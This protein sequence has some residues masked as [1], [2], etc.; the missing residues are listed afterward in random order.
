MLEIL[1]RSAFQSDI[2]EFQSSFP[3]GMVWG[4]RFSHDDLIWCL[5]NVALDR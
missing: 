4:K 3:F 2:A 5:F 1:P